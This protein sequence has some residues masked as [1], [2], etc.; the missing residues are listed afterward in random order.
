MGIALEIRKEFL[1]RFVP[2]AWLTQLPNQ[3]EGS[4]GRVLIQDRLCRMH[5]FAYIQGKR[6]EGLRTSRDIAGLVLEGIETHFIKMLGDINVLIINLDDD[7]NTPKEKLQEQEKRT[8]QKP[9]YPVNVEFVDE[10]VQVERPLE[11]LREVVHEVE[12]VDLS[13]VMD[14]RKIRKK[15]WHYVLELLKTRKLPEKAWVIFNY[16]K[17]GPWLFC[18]G[19]PGVH[20][21]E[22]AH[23]FGESDISLNFFCYLFQG[24]DILIESVDTDNIPI[25]TSYLASGIGPKSLIWKYKDQTTKNTE[26]VDMK[27][28]HEGALAASGLTSQQFVFAC[29]LCKTDFYNKAL[30]SHQMGPHVIFE[31]VCTSKDYLIHP[32]I[33]CLGEGKEKEK[34]GLNLLEEFARLLLTLVLHTHSKTPSWLKKLTVQESESKLQ[35]VQKR[36]LEEPE[37]G[38]ISSSSSSSEDFKDYNDQQASKRLKLNNKNNSNVPIQVAAASES[39]TNKFKHRTEVIQ[40]HRT[41][42]WKKE[43]IEGILR[44]NNLKKYTYPSKENINT[45]YKQ[46]QFNL[47]YWLVDWQK[48]SVKK[49]QKLHPF[50]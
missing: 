23:N 5:D 46:L 39:T 20:M 36:K 40:T 26:L 44:D 50:L 6:I 11:G 31:A 14:T 17:T 16:H 33:Q 25:T 13:K 42:I 35:T 22:W 21:T 32:L 45:A 27:V 10:G 49:E 30:I 18:D 43:E 47:N 8:A 34:E 1:R 24:Y 12:L 3:S 29:I 28:L 41:K 19:K 7:E 9:Q 37:W 4:K 15:L 38:I 2:R 48:Y